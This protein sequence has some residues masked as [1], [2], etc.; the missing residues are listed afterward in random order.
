[1]ADARVGHRPFVCLA[2][3]ADAEPAG[4]TPL[5]QWDVPGL[6]GRQFARWSKVGLV[7]TNGRGSRRP[8]PCPADKRSDLQSVA[9]RTPKV[10][11]FP[12]R[13]VRPWQTAT[14]LFDSYRPT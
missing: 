12:Q 14:T 13:E 1:M 7:L 9:P 6:P 4:W 5:S 3:Q 11:A 2:A 10:R 8:R